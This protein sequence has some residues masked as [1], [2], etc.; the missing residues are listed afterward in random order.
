MNELGQDDKNIKKEEFKQKSLN[1][2]F[3][4]DDNDD[5]KQLRLKR[6]SESSNKRKEVLEIEHKTNMEFT[7]R[8]KEPI[9][10]IQPRRRNAMT[11]VREDPMVSKLIKRKRVI[12][13]QINEDDSMSGSSSS[14]S[15]ISL[16]PQKK[17]LKKEQS[18]IR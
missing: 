3:L 16:Q 1:A 7:Q 14:L 6:K 4:F 8:K 5:Q 15:K 10:N 9:S 11:V 2:D 12:D 18:R 13:S 17:R